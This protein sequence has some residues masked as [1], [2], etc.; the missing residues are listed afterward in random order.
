MKWFVFYEGLTL[1]GT[2]SHYHEFLKTEAPRTN[3]LYGDI[4]GCKIQ[5]Y[6]P[7]LPTSVLQFKSERG[8]HK[9][10]KPT[11]MVEWILEYY[12]KEGDTVLDPT[13]G[14]GSTG[15]SCKP[16]NREF[17]GMDM[18]EEIYKVACG[19]LELNK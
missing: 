17:I 14:S 1:Y 7:P 13:T 15:V 10:Q 3:I 4:Q 8:K 9:T 12:S 19:R 6:E 18:G 16:M 2:S 5:K 11:T